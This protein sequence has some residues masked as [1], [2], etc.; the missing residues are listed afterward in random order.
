MS[1]AGLVLYQ[2]TFMAPARHYFD[3]DLPYLQG[4]GPMFQIVTVIHSQEVP[5][6]DAPTGTGLR[7][8]AQGHIIPQFP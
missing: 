1:G 6:D 5:I 4:L 3:G 8:A 2:I 7:L